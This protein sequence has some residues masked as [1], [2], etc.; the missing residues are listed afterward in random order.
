LD[1]SSALLAYDRAGN[2]TKTVPGTDGD[3]SKGFQ[4]VW[5]AWNRIVEVKDENGATIQQNAYD[6]LTR[7]ITRK[8]GGEVI[9]T[10]WSDRWKPLEERIDADTTA[11]RQYL[12]G[13]RP[14]HRDELVLRDRDTDGNGTLDE[15]LYA[16][17]DYFNGTAMLDTSGAVQERYAYSAF[18]VLRV[19]AADFTP[20]TGSDY[21]WEFG[22]QGQFRDEETGW[23]NYG[24]RFYVPELG[25]WINRD[26]IEEIGGKNLFALNPNDGLNYHDHLGLAEQDYSCCDDRTIQT[27]RDELEKRYKEALEQ[28]RRRNIL[29][30]GSGIRSCKNTSLAVINS[31]L[32]YPKCWTCELEAADRM[33]YGF[34][35]DHQVVLCFATKKDGTK[36]KEV[37]FDFWSGNQTGEDPKNF[38]SKW[39]YPK[40]TDATVPPIGEDCK[41]TIPKTKMDSMMKSRWDQ[42]EEMRRP[43]GKPIGKHK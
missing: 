17:M 23:L 22:F 32:P 30:G 34:G 33:P 16:T 38:R 42:M 11:A 25:R 13:E 26:L 5:D 39:N 4:P 6:G 31:F 24:Y 27:G 2:A 37:S 29:P 8:T 28:F 20:K 43:I 18:G 14:G 36:G 1:G 15:R 21:D 7:R 12:W 9:H 19:R 35:G 3:W 10:Y 41:H 40:P